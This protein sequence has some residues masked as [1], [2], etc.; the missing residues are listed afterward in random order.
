MEVCWSNSGIEQTTL[1]SNWPDQPVNKAL[2]M[3]VGD[4]SETLTVAPNFFFTFSIF[5][6]YYNKELNHEDT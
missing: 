2:T 5:P 4:V 3:E 1:V 6:L